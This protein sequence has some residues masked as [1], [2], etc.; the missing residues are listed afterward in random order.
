MIKKL[1]NFSGIS[2]IAI[3]VIFITFMIIKDIEYRKP[4]VPGDK[5]NNINVM[6]ERIDG[7][8]KIEGIDVLIDEDDLDMIDGSTA[9]I[10]IT[11]EIL[12]QFFDYTDDKIKITNAIYHSTTHSAYVNLANVGSNTKIIFVTPP[13]EDELDLQDE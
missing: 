6:L 1:L 10:P 8:K 3:T 2:I 13:S 12:R 7:W 9:T 5:T 4:R 11:A